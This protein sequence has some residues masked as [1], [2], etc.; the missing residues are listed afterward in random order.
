[1][2]D[3]ALLAEI[4]ALLE[5]LD[6]RSGGLAVAELLEGGADHGLAERRQHVAARLDARLGAAPLALPLE[7]LPEPQGAGHELAGATGDDIGALLRERALVR[8]GG[9][10]SELLGDCETE[11]AV[12]EELQSLV[13]LDAL[14][15][16]RRMGERAPAQLIGEPLD[17]RCE[18]GHVRR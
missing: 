16:P 9:A 12:A 4:D 14:L 5:R 1:V 8:A 2:V 13:G 15:D 7:R 18:R 11:H 6:D 17:E 3:E 10:A